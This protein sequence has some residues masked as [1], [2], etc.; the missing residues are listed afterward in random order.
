MKMA[1]DLAKLLEIAAA[2]IIGHAD[3]L[4]DSRLGHR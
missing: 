3:E 4:T 1:P 2:R